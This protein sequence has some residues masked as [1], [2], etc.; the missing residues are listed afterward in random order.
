MSLAP[1]RVA[2]YFQSIAKLIT[3][4]PNPQNGITMPQL[5]L[6]LRT[7]LPVLVCVKWPACSVNIF[8]Y[9]L[10]SSLSRCHLGWNPPL[11]V[12]SSA[13]A[14]WS[15]RKCTDWADPQVDGMCN[16][17][18]PSSVP[19]F[20]F[21]SRPISKRTTSVFPTRILY[22]TVSFRACSRDL[23]SRL[24]RATGGHCRFSPWMTLRQV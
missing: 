23:H 9:D 1:L 15:R 19:A 16:V 2:C 21:A 12:F 11:S 13:L 4:Y 10:A 22:V 18:P 14:P 24:V 6:K 20:T 3:G 5:L 17:V 8:T 7:F